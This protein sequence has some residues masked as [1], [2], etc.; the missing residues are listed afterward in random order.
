MGPA[1][2]PDWYADFETGPKIYT[3]DLS[4]TGPGPGPHWYHLAIFASLVLE[5]AIAT[6]TADP[7]VWLEPVA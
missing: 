5:A 2:D 3:P 1:P 7:P 4:G 6:G